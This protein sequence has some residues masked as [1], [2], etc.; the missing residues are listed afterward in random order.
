MLRKTK[1][2]LTHAFCYSYYMVDIDSFVDLCKRVIAD[3]AA[4]SLD[5]H[6]AAE[7]IYQKAKECS[8]EADVHPML[9][10]VS[11]LSFDIT[12]NYRSDSD[13]EADWD[14]IVKTIRNFTDGS[15]EPTC[16]ILSAMYGIHTEQRLIR[17]CSVTARRQ[18]GV[19]IIETA[20]N[21]LKA[22]FETIIDKIN[23]EQTDERYLQNLA[24]LAPAHIAEYKLESLG[25]AE[26]LTEPYYTTA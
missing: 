5:L 25:V 21:N 12:E 19:T 3:H 17:S 15:W 13:D 16:W 24:K 22:E 26:Y 4:R 7:K 23:T 1:K 9:C 11:D 14:T 10:K 6:V 2:A 8:F 18:N 20:V